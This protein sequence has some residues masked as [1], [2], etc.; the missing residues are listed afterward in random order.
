M[1]I[2]KYILRTMAVCRIGLSMVG[3]RVG[4]LVTEVAASKTKLNLM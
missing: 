2:L 4:K 1:I 3:E